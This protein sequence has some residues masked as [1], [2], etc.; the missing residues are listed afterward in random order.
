VFQANFFDGISAHAKSVLVIVRDNG[1]S[2]ETEGNVVHYTFSE[3]DVQA[4][5]GTSKRIIDLPDGA[6]LE[7]VD[8]SELEAASPS[9]ANVFW[10]GVHYLEN[11]L[12]WVLV[13]LTA[14]VFFGWVFLQYGV[15]KL[16]EHVADA[17]PLSMERNLGEQVLKGLDHEYGYFSPSKTKKIR[18]ADIVTALN[19]LCMS[20]KS[21]PKYQLKFREG[22]VV[23]ANALALPGGIMIV[24]DELIQLAKNDTEIVAVLAHELGHVEGR[25]AFRQSIQSVLAGL[26]LAAATGDVSSMASG[27]PGVL[28]QMRYSRQHETD[29]DDFAL[30]ALQKACLPPKAFADFMLRFEQQRK[31]VHSHAGAD[32]KSKKSDKKT[33]SDK[34]TKRS[35]SP[36]SDLLSTHPDSLDRIK[37]FLTAKHGC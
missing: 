5:L 8:I 19:K 28:M 26:V 2:I 23:G 22:G 20:L 32:E 13:S 36:V 14:T 4:K 11:H 9:K 34:N 17:T 15:P 37:P 31:I 24:T 33:K 6:R 25:H 1:L 35:A 12:G 7:A 27:L 10:R 18:Q 16:A 21:C 30:N 3:L 29:A